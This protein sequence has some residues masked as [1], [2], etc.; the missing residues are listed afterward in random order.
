[1]NTAET[2][3]V[4]Y[5]EHENMYCRHVEAYSARNLTLSTDILN[6]FQGG[7]SRTLYRVAVPSS[8]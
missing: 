2:R 7:P 4:A 5:F 1:M 3:S 8:A 6:A